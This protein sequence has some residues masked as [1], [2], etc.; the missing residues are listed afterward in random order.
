MKWLPLSNLCLILFAFS[1][2]LPVNGEETGKADAKPDAAALVGTWQVIKEAFPSQP[3]NEEVGAVHVFH[4]DGL[5]EIYAPTYEARFHYRVPRPGQLQWS[6]AGGKFTDCGIYRVEGKSLTWRRSA[7]EQ[8]LDFKSKP[9][10]QWN[11]YR[12]KRL[13]GKEA[14]TAIA[15]MKDERLTR[16]A[17][18]RA[19]EE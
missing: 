14:N 18:D 1:A 6:F 13:E 7:E 8:P 3:D 16:K 5:L 2:C 11:E 15:K 19:K 17:Q 10:G 4:D 9:K 12:L